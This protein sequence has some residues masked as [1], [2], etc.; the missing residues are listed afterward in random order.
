MLPRGMSHQSILKYLQLNR[1][2][3]FQILMGHYLQGFLLQQFH[4]QMMKLD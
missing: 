1:I 4:L 3:A 2:Q